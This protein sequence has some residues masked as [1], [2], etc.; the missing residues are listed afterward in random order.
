MLAQSGKGRKSTTIKYM[1]SMLAELMSLE[2]FIS[3]DGSHQG[4]I[5]QIAN[6]NGQAS[7]Q[8]ND[9][10]DDTILSLAS[11]QHR[12]DIKKVYKELYQ[13]EEYLYQN[14]DK[15]INGEKKQDKIHINKPHFNI[16]GAA[17]QNILNTLQHKDVESGFIGRFTIIWPTFYPET[18]IES[19]EDPLSS[20]MWQELY[21]YCSKL[22]STN[23]IGDINVRFNN[24]DWLKFENFSKELDAIPNDI[25][26]RYHTFSIKFAMLIE[27]SMNLPDSNVFTISSHSC[28]I[29][30]HLAKKYLQ[31]ALDFEY[32]VGGKTDWER[33]FE[34]NLEKA[35]QFIIEN[36]QVSRTD[37]V[38]IF[39][40]NKGRDLDDILRMLKDSEFIEEQKI[41]TGGRDK[42]IYIYIE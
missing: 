15:M 18:N 11:Q 10:F 22:K 38:R 6:N 32:L 12:N 35:K 8:I 42:S 21:M 40:S 20:P 24:E 2:A 37:L 13:E 4:F 31:Y 26:K 34:K 30:I 5:Q 28:D 36:K 14:R 41:K 23:D 3:G 17:T 25:I 29:G 33:R 39:K 19:Q 1:K 16:M 7:A 27:L 9:E